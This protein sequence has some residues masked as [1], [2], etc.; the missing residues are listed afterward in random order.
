MATEMIPLTTMR[1]LSLA[2][3]YPPE[4]GAS[5]LAGRLHRDGAHECAAAPTGCLL[6]A[7]L[8]SGLVMATSFLFFIAKIWFMSR[9]FVRLIQM[10][11][12][13]QSFKATCMALR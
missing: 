10:L 12:T 3:T 4:C 9:R 2:T 5:V 8:R 1:Q 13:A 7:L 11:R 6:G